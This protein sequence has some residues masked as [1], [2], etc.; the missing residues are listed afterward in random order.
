MF[1]YGVSFII[2]FIET[3]FKGQENYLLKN[4]T[5]KIDNQ[6]KKFD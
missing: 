2:K 3:L 6:K 1:F 4:I 5:F